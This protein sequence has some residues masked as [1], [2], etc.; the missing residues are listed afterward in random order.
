MILEEKISELMV[1]TAPKV[2]RVFVTV[3]KRGKEILY[4]KLQISV[5]IL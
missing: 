3:G 5:Q 4:V 1:L 2:F